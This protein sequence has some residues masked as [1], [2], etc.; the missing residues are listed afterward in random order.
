MTE[1][2][3]NILA[4]FNTKD[5]VNMEIAE[6]TAIATGNGIWFSNWI[7]EYIKSVREILDKYCKFKNLFNRA[8]LN[9]MYLQVILNGIYIEPFYE[10][11]DVWTDVFTL[12]ENYCTTIALETRNALCYYDLQ[13]ELE[14]IGV[15]VTFIGI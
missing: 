2:Q 15:K 4:L 9:L 13:K 3:Q 8:H 1:Q 6:E 12:Y 5:P 14:E 7:D 11:T 10:T